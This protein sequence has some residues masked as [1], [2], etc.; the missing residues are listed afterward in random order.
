MIHGDH[1][2]RLKVQ[3]RINMLL[4]LFERII[5]LINRLIIILVIIQL[6]LKSSTFSV[7]S[8]SESGHSS[9]RIYKT[10]R[11]SVC[12]FLDKLLLN[13]PLER[14]LT[15]GESVLPHELQKQY[16]HGLTQV[17]A[18]E[19]EI[20]SIYCRN[21][22]W[23]HGPIIISNLNTRTT[24]TAHH[25]VPWWPLAK[26]SDLQQRWWRFIRSIKAFLNL[27]SGQIT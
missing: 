5:K 27:T 9:H 7:M 20:I 3:T 26:N 25:Q 15:F 4:N 13:E 16:L 1:R 11:D 23:F 14:F 2:W 22:Q 21:L 6:A 12:S 10:F 18:F 24:L 19:K 17:M 8:M